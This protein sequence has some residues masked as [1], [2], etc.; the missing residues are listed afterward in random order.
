MFAAGGYVLGLGPNQVTMLSA[1]CSAAGIAVIAIVDPSPVSAV[2]SVALLV[3]GYGL[4]SAD[5]QLARL[6]GTGSK[7]GEWLDHTVDATKIVSL[8]LALLISLYRFGDLDSEAWLLL[9]MAFAVTSSVLFFSWILRDLLLAGTEFSTNRRDDGRSS[10]VV[11]SLSRVLED[12]GV[13]MFVLLALPAT[14]V[15]LALYTTL[16]AWSAFMFVVAIP[17]RFRTIAANA[18]EGGP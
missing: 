7:A 18:P 13:L 14:G 5:G 8:H 17:K 1:A 4:D 10:S 3:I 11:A 12:Y 9:P 2:V 15:F 6:T 16:F